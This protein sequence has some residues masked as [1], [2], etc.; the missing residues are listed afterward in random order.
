MVTGGETRISVVIIA[1]HSGPA[2]ARCLDSLPPGVEV[3]VVDNGGTEQEDAG[4]ARVIEPGANI[5]FAAG[6][7][8]GAAEAGGDVLVFLNPDT[9]VDPDAL[10]QRLSALV[11]WESSRLSALTA[12]SR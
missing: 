4:R 11:L 6:C 7:N 12:T 1:F 10:Q 5:G 9:V 2:L 8:L 3:I